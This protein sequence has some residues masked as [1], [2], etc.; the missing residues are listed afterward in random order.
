[1]DSGSP[2]QGSIDDLE[3]LYRAKARS[4]FNFFLAKGFTREDS[5]ELVQ[6]TFLE[7]HRS[8]HR[9]EGQSALGTWLIAV[10]KN[11]WRKRVRDS[12]RQ[13]RS[14]REVALDGIEDNRRD[15]I[16]RSWAEEVSGASSVDRLI[17]AERR[18]LVRQAIEEL[19]PRQRQCLRMRVDLGLRYKDIAIALGISVSTAKTNVRDARI[20]LADILA[21]S[22]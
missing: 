6:E 7:A 20:R 10:A 18:D 12:L 2:N 13:K 19:P 9:F 5:Q 17:E 3:E 21:T 15:S 14:G 4:V 22:R 1:M 16:E 11:L 8:M